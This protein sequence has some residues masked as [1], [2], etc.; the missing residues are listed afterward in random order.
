MSESY[1]PNSLAE[2]LGLLADNPDLIPY[3]GGTDLMVAEGPGRSFLFLH[4]VPGL[5]CFQLQDDVLY[6]GAG[7]TYSQLL[8]DG[9]TP[10]LLREAAQSVAAPALRNAATIGGNVA[11][12]SPKGDMALALCAAGATVHLASAKA[13][14]ELPLRQF[15]IGR[16]KTE[17]R[18]DELITAFAIPTEW[19]DGYRF[20]KVGGRAALAISRVSFA[21]LCTVRD[22]IVAHLST[23]FGAVEDTIVTR[24]QLDATLTGKTVAQARAALPAYLDSYAAAL[25][26]IAGRVSADYRRQVCLN[27]LR[28]FLEQKLGC[29]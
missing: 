20:E 5:R 17:R 18:P 2:A 25:N 11:N 14:R 22:G 15:F 23:A 12:A 1:T 29:A 24:P 6:L 16:N 4:Q 27:L 7:L 21:G 8:A 3:A 26:P 13:T 28:D 19:L 9:R 10:A